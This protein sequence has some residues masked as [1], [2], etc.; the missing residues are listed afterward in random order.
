MKCEMERINYLIVGIG[1]NVN[2]EPCDFHEDVKDTATSIF[3]EAG[4]KI[5]RTEL[6]ESS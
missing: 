2:I 6:L 5:N 4:K 3:I 1:I